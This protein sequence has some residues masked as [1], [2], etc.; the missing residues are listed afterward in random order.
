MGSVRYSESRSIVYRKAET[1][2]TETELLRSATEM[3]IKE[4]NAVSA[5][6]THPF[7]Y[8]RNGVSE[9]PDVAKTN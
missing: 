7:G 5:V 6:L 2:D 8:E 4:L 3:R 9:E 1:L